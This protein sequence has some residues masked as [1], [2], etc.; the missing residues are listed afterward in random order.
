MKGCIE[1]FQTLRMLQ[2]IVSGLMEKS[3][4]ENLGS[5][6]THVLRPLGDY[7]PEKTC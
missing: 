5:E 2:E 3:G 4:Y 1:V 7:F 6:Q